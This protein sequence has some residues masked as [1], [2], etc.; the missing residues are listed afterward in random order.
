MIVLGIETSC[1]ETASSICKNG[2][3]LSSLVGLQSIHKKFGGVVPEIASREHDKILNKI[4]SQTLV[5]AKISIGSINGIAV[6]QGPGLTGTLLSGISFAKGLSVGLNIPII[7]INHLEAHIFA[8]FLADENLDFPFICLLVSGGHTQIWLVKNLGDYKLLGETRDDAAGEAFDKGARI[9]GLDYPGGPEIEK[10]ALAGD[11]LSINFPRPLMREKNLEF[12]F[13]GLKTALLYYMDKKIKQ[14]IPD[15]AASYQL[16]IIDVLTTKL[17]WAMDKTNCNTCVI[18]GG[19]AANKEL[20][21]NIDKL[22]FNKN[23]IFPDIS[24]CTDNA[25]MV[26]YLGELYLKKNIESP[27]DFKVFPNMKMV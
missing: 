7:G 18:A 23:I 14:D 13:S 22:L 20:R 16:A 5:E 4:V 19:V 6:T 11:K 10:I 27:I 12:S 1:D 3:I 8:N 15:I 24:L 21:N 25:A 26:A 2:V 17:K 9:L